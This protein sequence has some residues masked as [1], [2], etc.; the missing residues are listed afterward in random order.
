[1]ADYFNLRIKRNTAEKLLKL[2]SL[3]KSWDNV[4][5]EL[6][7]PS[8]PEVGN[9]R[10]TEKGAADIGSAVPPLSHEPQG[11]V[12]KKKTRKPE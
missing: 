12:K 8:T 7:N 3:G 4:V 2:K 1:M 10:P 6:L 9:D 11:S 5:A